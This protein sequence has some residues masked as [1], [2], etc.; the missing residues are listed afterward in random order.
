MRHPQVTVS[1]VVV[2]VVAGVSQLSFYC[3]LSMLVSQLVAPLFL[4]DV[5]GGGGARAS[6]A[7]AKA[8][9]ASEMSRRRL[10]L[11]ED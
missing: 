3:L 5:G 4:L 10:L 2:V 6:A 7:T 8:E 11:D 1:I 9:A